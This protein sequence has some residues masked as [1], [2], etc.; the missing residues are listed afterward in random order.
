MNLIKDYEKEISDI[1]FVRDEY[2]IIIEDSKSCCIDSNKICYYLQNIYNGQQL[3]SIMNIVNNLFMK[4]K[5]PV[6]NS[7]ELFCCYFEKLLC[8][9]NILSRYLDEFYSV[10]YYN[11]PY[12]YLLILDKGEF[13]RIIHEYKCIFPYGHTME[14]FIWQLIMDS[15]MLIDRGLY[16]DVITISDIRY[17]SYSDR[18]IK[19]RDE[20]LKKYYNKISENN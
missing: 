12:T 19:Y 5:L 2:K 16:V 3:L 4:F 18:L 6:V 17:C 15:E 9:M 1:Q 7:K 14:I 10:S 20:V 13:H 11:N 8:I